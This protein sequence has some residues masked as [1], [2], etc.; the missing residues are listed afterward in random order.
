MVLCKKS[1]ELRESKDGAIH[2]PGRVGDD[3]NQKEYDL[4]DE[5]SDYDSV[6][7]GYDPETDEEVVTN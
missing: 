1:F 4:E 3:E 6:G 7:E 5:W 2:R